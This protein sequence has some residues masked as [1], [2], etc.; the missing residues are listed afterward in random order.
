MSR[1]AGLVVCRTKTTLRGRFPQAPCYRAGA[2]PNTMRITH[3]AN[4]VDAL[5]KESLDVM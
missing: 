1:K 4:V 5:G 3:E 2:W